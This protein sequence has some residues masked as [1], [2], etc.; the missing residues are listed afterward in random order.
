MP[1]QVGSEY[2][3]CA[4]YTNECYLNAGFAIANTLFPTLLVEIHASL[5]K[6]G[7]GLMKLEVRGS[8]WFIFE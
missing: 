7:E 2:L 3:L 1:L 4:I 6:L 8:A 5:T